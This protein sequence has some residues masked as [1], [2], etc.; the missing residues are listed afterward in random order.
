MIARFETSVRGQLQSLRSEVQ[1][2]EQL[3]VEHEQA[4]QLVNTLKGQLEVE[5]QKHQQLDESCGVLRQT[6]ADL[7]SQVENLE[8]E[9]GNAKA[10]ACQHDSDPEQLEQTVQD[11]HMQLEQA[12]QESQAAREKLGQSEHHREQLEKELSKYKVLKR[13]KPTTTETNTMQEDVEACKAKLYEVAKEI[14]E[15]VRLR[16]EVL[17]FTL[18]D[19][20]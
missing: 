11:L 4:N 14:E 12:R 10:M 8:Q 6:E 15:K 9:L 17:V 3:L 16:V 5:Q 18:A 20:A 19:L 1:D 2:R 13:P 7:K